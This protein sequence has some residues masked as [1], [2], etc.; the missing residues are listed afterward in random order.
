VT[1]LLGLSVLLVPTIALAQ[2][3]AQSP[4]DPVVQNPTPKEPPRNKQP[5]TPPPAPAISPNELPRLLTLQQ[6]IDYALRLQP[7]VAGAV[8]N[9]E[10]ATERRI[11]TQSR[12]FPTITPS[13]QYNSQYNFGNVSQFVNSSSG[14]TIVTTQ[15][16]RTTTARQ[17][18]INLSYNL[19]DAGTRELSARQARQSLRASEYSETNT[20]QTVIANV[21]DSYFSVLRTDALVRVAQAQV[22]RAINT[23]DVVQA[24]FEAGVTAQ[25]DTFQAEADLLNAQV[26]LIQARN[27]AAVAQ[28][29]FKQALGVV[30]GQPVQLADVVLPS[31]TTPISATPAPPKDPASTGK[32]APSPPGEGVGP[33]EDAALIDQLAEIAYQTRPDIAANRQNLE[34]QRT[35]ASI[36]R[37]STG[38]Q[39]AASVTANEL[40][41]PVQFNKTTGNN[42][43]INLSLSYP[44][45]DA[46]F[47]RSQFRASQASARSVEA[48]LN[49]LRQSV[50]VEV[51]QGY[52]NLAQA[53]ASLPASAAAVRAARINY[54]AAIASRREGV[55]SIVDVITAQ[56][57]LVQA[58]TNYV[59]AIYNFYAADARLTRAVGQADK[60]AGIGATAPTNPPPIQFTDVTSATTP[61]APA[62]P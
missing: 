10:A 38:V 36:A 61:A 54:E 59:Q 46:G 9:R 5:E 17:S 21:A 19:F 27:N 39:V 50:A 56:T 57:S 3:K 60:I 41:D 37:I 13:F 6:S 43:Q 4:T 7:N 62:N 15:Q 32:T 29:T 16:G 55:G 42:R 25:K 11:G 45:F 8:A 14:A 12:Y 34:V 30:G 28:A 31:T 20:R 22:A 35:S 18:G 49:S 52:R 24:Q 23:R 48:Q 1:S 2:D 40:I 51:E 53:R 33:G 26:N 47:V 44:L 58:E